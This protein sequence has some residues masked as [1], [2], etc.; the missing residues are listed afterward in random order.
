MRHI[1]LLPCLFLSVWSITWSALAQPQ[2]DWENEHVFERNREA[3]CAASLMYPTEQAALAGR[4]TE[5][6]WFCSL[7]GPWKF[8]WAPD[9]DH[10]PVDFYRTEFD[11]AAWDEV[12]VPGNWQLQGYGVPLYSNIPYPFKADPPRV[13]SEPP[14]YYTTYT[15]RNPVGSYRRMFQ[16]P[17]QWS[18]RQ[19][20]VQ[21][22]GVDS[23]FYVWVNG[24]EIGYSEGSRTPATFNITKHIQTGQNT[25]AVEVYRYSDGSYLEDQDYWRLSGIYRNVF[26]WSPPD[27]HIRDFFVHAELDGE[28][29]DGS[30]EVEMDLQN[31]AKA[32]ATCA[33][34]LR[35]LDPQQQ[36][37]AEASQPVSLK[38]ARLT[39]IRTHRIK[40]ANPAKWTAETPQLYTLILA[41]RNQQGETLEARSHRIGFRKV[42]IRGG[43]L[44]VN[45]QPIYLKGVNRHEHDPVTGHVISVESMIRDIR[46]MKQLNI[47]AVRACHYPDD[48]A[49]YALCDT[50]GLYVVDEANIESHGMGYGAESLAKAPSWK[51]AHLD[52]VRRMVERDKNH[53]SIIIWSLGN[54]AGNGENFQACYDWIK[55]RDPSRPVQ[56][57][58]AQLEANT[59]IY[60][61]MYA[62]IEHIVAYASTPQQRPLILCEYAHAMGNSV[63]NLQD[64]WDAIESH[65]QLQ[66]GFIWDWLDQGLQAQVPTGH[67]TA[68]LARPGRRA[69]VLGK[70]A[71]GGVL[72]PVT[73]SDDQGLNLDGPLTLEAV[74]QGFQ[75]STYCP[76]I[77]KGDHQYLLRFN[78]QG[79]DFVIFQD[80]WVGLRVEFAEAG[81]T[82]DWNRITAVYDG[83]ALIAYVNGREVG[84]RAVQGPITTSTFPVNIGRNSEVPQ[85]VCCLS[86]GAARIYS[87]ALTPAEVADPQSRGRDGLQLDLD[88]AH[89]KPD[90]IP[91]GRGA[92]YFAYGGDFGD[93]PNDENFCCNGLLAPDC[94]LHPHAYEVQKVYQSIKV[95]P[96]DLTVG[97][98]R[99]HNKYF[100]TNLSQFQASWVVRRDGREVGSGQLG[101]LDVAPRTKREITIPLAELQDALNLPGEYLVTVSFTLPEETAWAERGHRVAWDQ[102]PLPGPVSPAAPP[103][104]S[105][106]GGLTL[107]ES[108]EQ[109]IVDSAAARVVINRHTGA[110]E[111]YRWQGRELLAAP[112]EPN[113]WKVPNDNQYRSQYLNAVQPWRNAARNRQVQRVVAEQAGGQVRV[114]AEMVLP[115]GQSAYHVTYTV[116][117]DS[118]I[119]VTCRYQ[120]GE[121][122][123][124][125]LP[126]FGMTTALPGADQ[127]ITWYGRG[128]QETYWDRKTGGEIAIHRLAVEEFI[129]P[130][131]RAQDNANRTDVRWFTVTDRDGH[132][133]RVTCG[134]T[135]LCFAVWPYTLQDLEQATHDYQLPRRDSLV[136]NIDHLL[137]GVGGDNSWG[138][139]THP[140]YTLP[141]NQPYE[142]TFTLA[143]A[144]G[145]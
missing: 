139:L 57:E 125:L 16:L 52:R 58:R 90:Q 124:P 142:Y 54:E 69:T 81:L 111:S 5:N 37:V 82:D 32:A 44:L 17:E 4:P 112:L 109:Y 62:S 46:L 103:A 22:D 83:R 50:L 75:H 35:L 121:S 140:Q 116:R 126:K 95:E 89:V 3:P 36:V 100:F 73:L 131:I 9:P 98:V 66:G 15:Q 48:P 137:H 18:G 115:V 13:T 93:Q 144:D 34:H 133:V 43:Q 2:P 38:A 88:L 72:G 101:R 97:T 76:L 141:G 65:A 74:V 145:A 20:M 10:R 42:E 78:N 117:A 87:R 25:I 104:T 30:L 106:Q 99:V 94:T 12:A 118:H 91:L 129:H 113:F 136:L 59:D 29:R 39:Q 122:D 47:N 92:T 51:E 8:H 130:Y 123:I 63:G 7:N 120:P 64:Y 45:G 110:L 19:V 84:R 1:L 31:F 134:G 28:Y 24:Q 21:F 119:E 128:P 102:L 26:L 132:G 23:A 6:P 33:V 49:W 40:L 55:Q 56:Y 14:R 11:V 105:Q 70:L 68:D 53:P 79:I 41:L 60:C 86:I 71:D 61:P 77:S 114:V 107:R 80:Q 27:Q 143:P 138:A 96:V 108:D 67:E 85:R 127:L 135:P